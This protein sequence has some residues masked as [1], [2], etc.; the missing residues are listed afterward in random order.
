MIDD[1]LVQPIHRDGRELWRTV[2]GRHGHAVYGPYRSTTHGVYQ[3]T[4]ELALAEGDGSDDVA[5][6][7]IEITGD[8]GK[9]LLADRPIRTSDLSTGLRRFTLMA[10]LRQIHQLEFR[11]YVNGATELVVDAAPVLTRVSGVLDEPPHDNLGEAGRNPERFAR[12][13]RRILRRLRPHV[14]TGI[15]KVRLGRSADGGY[16]C[17][18]DFEGLDTAFSFGINDD[19]SWDRDVAGRG[20][21]VHQFDHTVTDPAPDDPRMV[22]QAKRIDRVSGPDTQSLGD[23]IRQ[24]DKGAERPNLLLKMDIENSEWEVFDATSEEDLSRLAWIVCELHYFQGLAER[25]HRELVDRCL[26]KVGRH[27]T[28]VH[29]HSNVWGGYSSFANTVVPNVIEVT[30]V[31]R[32]L[33]DVIWTHELFPGPVDQSCDPDQPDFYLGSFAF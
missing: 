6:A 30:F 9:V 21:T 18:D 19:I 20:L 11:I 24:H 7:T 17:P 33:Y 3:V 12:D 32:A 25:D 15:G 8:H 14:L 1:T 22:F 27:F 13:T 28:V 23:L 10:V 4:F 5:C 16:I 31:N 29:V 26:E 2:A